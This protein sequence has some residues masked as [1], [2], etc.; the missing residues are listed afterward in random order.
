[1]FWLN[2]SRSSVPFGPIRHRAWPDFRNPWLPLNR[3]LPYM[4]HDLHRQHHHLD[5]EQTDTSVLHAFDRSSMNWVRRLAS[6]FLA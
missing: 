4:H 5:Q 3:Q 6:F 1:M 2:L